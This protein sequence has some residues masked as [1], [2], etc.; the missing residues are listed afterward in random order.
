[1][2]S[3]QL[4]NNIKIKN[5]IPNL[6]NFKS[7]KI[8][9]TTIRTIHNVTTPLNSSLNNS[10]IDQKEIEKFRKFSK[11][12]WDPKGELAGLHQLQPYRVKLIR[13][14]ICKHFNISENNC[15]PFDS[16]IAIDVGCGAGIFTESLARLGANTLGIDAVEQSI[17]IAKQHSQLDPLVYENVKYE[18]E[19]LNNLINEGKQFDIVTSLE[20][21]EHVADLS[22]FICSLTKLLKPGGI[23]CLSTIN[24]TFKSYAL[25][26]IAAEN[27]LNWVAPGTHDWSKFVQPEELISFIEQ[28]DC[29]VTQTIGLKYNIFTQQWDVTN[30]LSINYFLFATKQ[31]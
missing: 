6:I 22:N 25:A 23:I 24:R 2:I 10:T 30:D 14:I 1:M 29:N 5:R 12:W 17:E 20:V 21:I 27:I 18:C 26:I 15:K 13:S 8:N 4:L 9:F 28:N 31:K 16:L 11:T 19:N 7:S 3:K